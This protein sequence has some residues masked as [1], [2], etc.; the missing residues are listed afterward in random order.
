[1]ADSVT[2]QK[3]ELAGPQKANKSW[4]D[5]AKEYLNY[6]FTTKDG[7][8][9]IMYWFLPITYW[10]PRYDWR[11]FWKGDIGA[12]VTVAIML[13]PQGMAYA[14]IAGLEPIYGLYSSTI[15]MFIYVFFGTSRQLSVAPVA[16]VSIL[17]SEAI[18]EV[19]HDMDPDDPDYQE[20]YTNLAIFCCFLVGAIQ[21]LMG[22]IRLGFVVTA[23]SPAVITGFTSAGAIIIAVSQLKHIFGV[24]IER[25][26][27]VYITFYRIMEQLPNTLWLPFVMGVLSCI[28]IYGLQRWKRLFPAALLILVVDG[29]IAWAFTTYT[30]I[31]IPIVGT[32]PGGVPIPKIP[33]VT[34]EQA[35]QLLPGAFIIS[36]VG[37]MESI[38]VAK[39]YAEKDN[40]DIDG[41]QELFGL[42]LANIVGGFFQ[43]YPVTG[44]FS[45]TAVNA[46]AGSK[47]LLASLLTSLIV[48]LAVAVLTVAFT[49]IP[50]TALASIIIVAVLKLIEVHKF[51]YYWKVKMSDFISSMVTFL[52]TLAVGIEIGILIGIGTSLLMVVYRSSR[53]HTAMLGA[54]RLEDEDE[55][56]HTETLKESEVRFS[57]NG[58]LPKDKNIFGAKV[59]Y[60]NLKR[61]ENAVPIPHV[62]IARMDASLY[63]ANTLFFTE[64]LLK[65][66][67]H[68]IHAH[69]IKFVILDCSSI[70]DVDATGVEAL[71]K[72]HRKLK[73]DNCTL[74]LAGVRGP[75]GDTLKR[76]DAVS[77]I[78]NEN[79]Y[80]TL[81]QA[82]ETCKLRI[83]HM[84]E[85]EHQQ[86][87]DE[88]GVKGES[89]PLNDIN[90]KEHENQGEETEEGN[91][92]DELDDEHD[93]DGEKKKKKK[94]R[95]THKKKSMATTEE[96]HLHEGDHVEEAKSDEKI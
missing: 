79:F 78:G 95:K 53:P 15:P 56:A 62:S 33:V 49:Y 7:W 10:L 24:T 5:H 2:Y 12:G 22:F 71:L 61:W 32:V 83:K 34:S 28:A 25:S 52:A 11:S 92:H 18:Y 40:L 29:V 68:E 3:V 73:E 90:E 46:T 91:T 65:Y 4:K 96:L 58:E 36:I 37:F 44:G 63:F 55:E 89:I 42:G 77:E 70:N 20:I 1:M 84:E 43:C 21:G 88:K 16:I 93:E 48:L 64:K 60:R 94:K 86:H 30:D 72:V 14:S 69:A 75:V 41:S 76:A 35:I 27:Y 31:P 38:S 26:S 39:K 17:V 45:R 19:L 80:F 66:F 47:S 74:V 51:K 81:H 9:G 54:V 82:V 57:F 6:T 87:D 50:Q 59:I 13:I 8:L 23:L 67:H 85:S